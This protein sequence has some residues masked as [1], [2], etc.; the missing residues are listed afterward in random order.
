LC[1]KGEAEHFEE[2]D[3]IVKTKQM[4]RCWTRTMKAYQALVSK[5]ETKHQMSRK[6]G[7]QYL[8]I[9]CN[10]QRASIPMAEKM[11]QALRHERTR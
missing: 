1:T 7:M 4:S 8:W 10:L 5:C 2:R 11:D 3:K 6:R 9:C